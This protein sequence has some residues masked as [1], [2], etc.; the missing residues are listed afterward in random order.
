MSV[1]CILKW[2]IGIGG[3]GS[4]PGSS[5]SFIFLEGGMPF[6]IGHFVALECLKLGFCRTVLENTLYMAHM[7]IH[8]SCCNP[9]C[10]CM[11]SQNAK[12]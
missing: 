8:S 9:V 10:P 12:D 6:E 3:G 4:P 11:H 1:L 5:E 2:G 7:S